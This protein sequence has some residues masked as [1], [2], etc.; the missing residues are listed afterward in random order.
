MKTG[1]T[2]KGKKA[3]GMEL[4]LY[5]KFTLVSNRK[6]CEFMRLLNV[7][8][9]KNFSYIFVQFQGMKMNVP[10]LSNEEGMEVEEDIALC[11]QLNNQNQFDGVSLV[12]TQS[13]S[14]FD[15]SDAESGAKAFFQVIKKKETPSDANKSEFEDVVTSITHEVAVVQRK[16]ETGY[17]FILMVKGKEVGMIASI[18]E[19]AVSVG[20][21]PQEE[22]NIHDVVNTFSEKN[23]ADSQREGKMRILSG[24]HVFEENRIVEPIRIYLEI[25]KRTV[26]GFSPAALDFIGPGDQHLPHS[27]RKGGWLAA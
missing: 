6:G 13:I 1:H 17:H 23:V 5:K 18:E 4:Y 10:M 2:S 25:T 19:V 26:T 3:E 21:P 7:R 8:P 16:T 20:A 24:G 11:V 15:F 12:R 27:N 14:P 9:K 22:E